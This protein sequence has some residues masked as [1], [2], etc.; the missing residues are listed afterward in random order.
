MIK[1]F[2]QSVSLLLLLVSC[3]TSRHVISDQF[4]VVDSVLDSVTCVNNDGERF[5]LVSKLPTVSIKDSLIEEICNKSIALALNERLVMFDFLELNEITQTTKKLSTKLFKMIR[6][7]C[8]P[9]EYGIG[10]I[11]NDYVKLYDKN[12]ILSLQVCVEHVFAGLNI[13]CTY[14]CLDVRTGE[15]MLDAYVFNSDLQGL[16]D[17]IDERINT[18][19]VYSK[20]QIQLSDDYNEVEKKEMIKELNYY[21][22]SV[23]A[24]PKE[25]CVTV[26]NG[27]AGILFSGIE[28]LERLPYK[29]SSFDFFFTLDELNPYLNKEFV[30]RI[31]N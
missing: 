26:D 28:I 27:M 6:D 13:D 3:H 11:S 24:L 14:I 10:T 22:S 5:T 25:W 31:T 4:V 29:M 21:H 12:D 20:R 8:S 9:S 16:F 30:Q 2:I 15:L 17:M 23:T 19:I 1:T 7:N 18:E